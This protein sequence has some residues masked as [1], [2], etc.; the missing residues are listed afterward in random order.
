MKNYIYL[1]MVVLSISIVS[2]DDVTLDTLKVYVND[3][4]FSGADEDGGEIRVNQ[5]DIVDL[6]IKLE[7]SWE[8]ETDAEI[9]ATLNDIDDGDDIEKKLDWF[10]IKGEDDKIKTVSFVIP[11]TAEFEEFDLE[12]EIVYKDMNGSEHTIDVDFTVDVKEKVIEDASN[13]FDLYESFHNLTLISK[14]MV[15]GLD[16]CFGYISLSQN[17]STELGAC[18]EDYGKYKTDYDNAHTDYVSCKDSLGNCEDNL[19]GINAEHSSQLSAKEREIVRLTNANKALL[20]PS[21]CRNQTQ[22]ALTDTSNQKSSTLMWWIVGGVAG[23][24]FW[25]N[26]K[27]NRSWGESVTHNR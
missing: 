21:Q 10:P 2:A 7:N 16:S 14:D 22:T 23:V 15:T 9:T 11:S 4:R 3:E 25:Q 18:K 1:L 5:N 12:V 17:M 20:T 27:K 13:T 26:K 8:N 6:V 24:I 19:K